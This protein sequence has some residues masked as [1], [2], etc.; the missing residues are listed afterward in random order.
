LRF[1]RRITADTN[2]LDLVD[3]GEAPPEESRHEGDACADGERR[4]G[5]PLDRLDVLVPARRVARVG[6]ERGNLDLGRPIS[7]SVRTSTGMPR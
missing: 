1:A 4:L 6:C 7:I 5:L 2:G 3:V